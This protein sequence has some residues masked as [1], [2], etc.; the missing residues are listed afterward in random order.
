MRKLVSL[1]LCIVMSFTLTVSAFAAEKN[2]FPDEYSTKSI[3]HYNVAG[4]SFDISYSQDGHV[5][6]ATIYESNGSV[7]ILTIND[8]TGVV[9][10]NGNILQKEVIYSD[11]QSSPIPFASEDNW[12]KPVTDIVALNFTSYTLAAIV[13]YLQLKYGIMSDKASYIAGLII[14]AGGFMYVKAVQQFNYVDYAPKVGYRT[15]ESLHLKSDASDAP[16]YTRTLTGS[17]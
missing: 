3:Q 17:R 16:L 12:G 13:G 4:Q 15:T 9:T 10:Y 14:S 8:D 1:F 7:S 11:A 2:Y 5:R 6:T